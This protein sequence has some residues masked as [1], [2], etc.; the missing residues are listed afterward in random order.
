MNVK[1]EDLTVHMLQNPSQIDKKA[2]LESSKVYEKLLNMYY[3]QRNKEQNQVELF[4]N[5][6]SVL[7]S[8]K[9]IYQHLKFQ[10]AFAQHLVTLADG[11]ELVIDL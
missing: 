1:D 5:G 8:P 4:L 2:S 6:Q 10:T 9:I 7:L 11:M 3:E